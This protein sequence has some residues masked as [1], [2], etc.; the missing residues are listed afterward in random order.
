M[1][2]VGGKVSWLNLRIEKKNPSKFCLTQVIWIRNS[3]SLFGA[4]KCKLTNL[5][6]FFF[7]YHSICVQYNVIY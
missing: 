6:H 1:S 3:I 2:S 5:I 7:E 4:K